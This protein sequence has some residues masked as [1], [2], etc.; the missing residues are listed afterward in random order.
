MILASNFGKDRR[1]FFCPKHPNQ[2]WG[3]HSLV[4][5]GTGVLSQD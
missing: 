4:Y 1:F 2:L 5:K 3:S